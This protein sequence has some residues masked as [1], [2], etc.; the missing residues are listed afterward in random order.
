[1]ITPRQLRF[2]VAVLKRWRKNISLNP[3]MK[4]SF[5]LP[6]VNGRLHNEDI[7]LLHR[8]FCYGVA[9]NISD[10]M[11]KTAFKLVQY[12]VWDIL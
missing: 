9:N 1:M 10:N 6:F 2:I 12:I 3:E 7:N 5:F 4:T 8:R 11:L